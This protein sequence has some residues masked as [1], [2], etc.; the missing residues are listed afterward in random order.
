VT[1]GALLT[2]RGLL[3]WALLALAGAGTALLARAAESGTEFYDRATLDYW[4]QRYQRST[5]KILNEVIHPALL[6][7]ERRRLAHVR[8]DM[9]LYAEGTQRGRPLA[10]YAPYDGSRVV[11]PVYSLKFLDDL[12]TA[13]AWLQINGYSLETISDYTA[14]LRYGNARPT[15]EFA[16]L[17][18]LGIPANALKDPRVDELALGHFVTARTFILLH[19]LGHAYHRHR[20][21]IGARSR[22]NEE[23][24]DRFAAEVMARTPLPPLGSLVFF[25][26]DASWA[27]Y[28][29]TAE[30]THPLSGARLRTLANHVED[31][32]LAQGLRQLAGLM[33][34][35]DI[36][37]GFAAAGKSATLESLKPRRSGELPGRARP[38]SNESF[39]GSYVGQANQRGDAAFPVRIDFRR[40]GNRVQGQ[41]SFGIGIGTIAGRTKGRRLDFEW[42][43]AGNHGRG[44]F[45]ASHDGNAFAGT[46]GYRQSVDNAGKWN[47]KRVAAE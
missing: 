15:P 33:D 1:R 14:M 5:N 32:G 22:K 7:D 28:P 10:F 25:M 8:L 42:Q 39:S 40:Q 47:G 38:G 31:R 19:E 9:P 44:V 37:T 13:Y 17:K 46:W 29:S 26:A 21:G 20:G 36:R 35:P 23:A 24:A 2:A 6:S 34:D 16:P 43:W 27:G 12:C 11:M 4:G 18:A 30:D 45:E 3:G 41:Y